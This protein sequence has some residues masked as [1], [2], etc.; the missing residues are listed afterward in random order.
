MRKTENSKT[1][2]KLH[3]KLSKADQKHLKENVSNGIK[4]YCKTSSKLIR[5]RKPAG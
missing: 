5:S 1:S 2:G 3:V 4:L